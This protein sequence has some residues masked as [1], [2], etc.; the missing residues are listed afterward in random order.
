MK[1][2]ISRS[3]H[4]SLGRLHFNLNHGLD[5]QVRSQRTHVLQ[6]ARG[7]FAHLR[8]PTTLA[9]SRTPVVQSMK[10]ATAQ[11][12][13][14]TR[15]DLACSSGL[16]PRGKQ[17][18]IRLESFLLSGSLTPD[19]WANVCAH[20]TSYNLSHYVAHSPIFSSFSR[21]GPNCSPNL[22]RFAPLDAL[23]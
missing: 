11:Q 17:C 19:P 14:I 3:H 16:E 5:G 8:L 15:E 4:L 12:T 20:F 18:I 13:P 21:P 7:I 22:Q 1:R 23:D 6:P 2:T 10:I 9:L